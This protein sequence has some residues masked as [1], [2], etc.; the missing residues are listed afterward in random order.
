MAATALLQ[1]KLEPDLK[2]LLAELA[3]Y[4]GLSMTALAKS[5]LKHVLRQKKA[6]IYTENGLLPKEELEILKRENEML[7]DYKKGKLRFYSAKQL[8][9]KLHA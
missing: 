5:T 2:Q 7:R 4:E 9:R 3:R 8:I 6:K 1:L